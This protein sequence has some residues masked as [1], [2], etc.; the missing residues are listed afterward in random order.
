MH[1]GATIVN[2]FRTVLLRRDYAYAAV[3]AVLAFLVPFL[4]FTNLHIVHSYYQTANAI[5]IIAAVGLGLA[6]VKRR[7]NRNCACIS[8]YDRDRATLVFP[9]GLRRFRDQRLFS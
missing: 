3:A 5:F 1:Q 4:V 6:A 9:V 7:A 2:K 8:R